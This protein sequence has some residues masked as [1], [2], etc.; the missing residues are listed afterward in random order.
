MKKIGEKLDLIQNSKF[1][2]KLEYYQSEEGKKQ[3]AEW[4]QRHKE[5]LLKYKIFDLEKNKAL[6][7]AHLEIFSYPA[8]FKTTFEFID[9]YFQVLIEKAR[10]TNYSETPHQQ[11][12][13]AMNNL[14]KWWFG[15]LQARMEESY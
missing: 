12:I 9:K 10:L 3:I 11:R 4:K 2:E 15:Y 14:K 7:N 5:I 6:E 13:D 8:S 1:K